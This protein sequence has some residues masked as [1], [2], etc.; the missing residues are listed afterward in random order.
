MPR[1][2]AHGVST[3]PVAE[4]DDSIPLSERAD[5]LRL[6]LDIIYP[7]RGI[8]ENVDYDLPLLKLTG[9]AAIK[10]EMETALNVIRAFLVSRASITK[11]NA[12]QLYGVAWDLDFTKEAKTLSTETLKCNLNALDTQVYLENMS[13]MSPQS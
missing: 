5:V 3:N 11:Y 2:R 13:V 6:L 8:S 10:Y 9:L 7:D 12:V 1:P 4:N